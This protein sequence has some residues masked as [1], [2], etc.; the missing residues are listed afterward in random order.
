MELLQNLPHRLAGDLGACRPGVPAPAQGLQNHLDVGVAEAAAGHDHPLPVRV[1]DEGRADARN[2]QK[3]IRR[4]GGGHPAHRMLRC[5]DGNVP[6]VHLCVLDQTVFGHR[7]VQVGLE[8]LAHL[9]GIPPRPAE[10]G[11]RLEGSPPSA[12]GE[13]FGVQHQPRHQRLRLPGKQVCGFHQVADQLA[14][15]LAGGRSVGL[16]EIE[17]RPLDIG[18]GPPVVVNDRHL[19]AGIQQLPVL[20][21]LRAVGVHHD[22]QGAGIRP[23][24]GLLGIQQHTFVLRHPRHPVIELIRRGPPRL[25]DDIVAHPL[26]PGDGANPHGGPHRVE[27]GGAVAHDHDA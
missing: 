16:V 25:P 5:G 8:Q 22:Q 10:H 9:A 2:I 23:E 7:V 4:L 26:H 6:A 1:E 19:V 14:D 11:R 17:V 12:H 27:V 3:L 13:I 18:G 15:Q 20:H 21:L 24:H